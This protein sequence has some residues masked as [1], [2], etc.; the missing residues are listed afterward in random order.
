MHNGWLE[1]SSLSNGETITF[2]KCI[3]D[4]HTE[5]WYYDYQSIGYLVL[6]GE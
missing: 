6:D 5:Y 4:L 3:Y 2:Q 1:E